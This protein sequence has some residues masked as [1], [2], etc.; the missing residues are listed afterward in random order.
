MNGEQL[1]QER[2]SRNWEQLETAKKLKL[3][4]PYLSL[5]ERGKRPVTEKLARR[6]VNL[7]NLPPT[8]LPFE[9]QIKSSRPNSGNQLASQLAGL[10]YPKF[11]HLKKSTKVNPAVILMTAL[12]TDELESRTVEA[13]PWLIFNFPEMTWTNII[14]TAK[15]YDAQNR[16]GFLL[17]IVHEKA[18]TIGD[19]NKKNLFKELLSVLEQSRL[20]REDTLWQKSLTETEKS[21]L[22]E[23]RPN[24]ASFWR[25]L[26]N[27]SVKHLT[28]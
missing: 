9:S 3:S 27:L 5:I 15:L 22:K 28:F 26:S 25:V 20:L 21:W 23:K 24:N 2:V 4:Q 13:L 11:S 14:K 7:F 12:K 17:S 1:F 10:G 19:E 18:E 8:A 16:L 6:A